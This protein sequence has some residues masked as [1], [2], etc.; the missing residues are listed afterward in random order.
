LNM[1]VN[2]GGGERTEAEFQSLFEAAGFHLTRV[3]PTQ[4]PWSII[5][6]VLTPVASDNQHG[7]P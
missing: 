4:T 5:E 3:V 2:T 6:G 7:R 1:L